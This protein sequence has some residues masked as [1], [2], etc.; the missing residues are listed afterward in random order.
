MVARF[1]PSPSEG[2][3]PGSCTKTTASATPLPSG[4]TTRPTTSAAA[5]VANA[6][7]APRNDVARNRITSVPET[8]A[9][10]PAALRGLGYR[11]C[12]PPAVHPHVLEREPVS[13]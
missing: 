11:Q 6:A 7:S 8:I 4:P 13:K 5:V 3:A 9:E 2:V 10:L 1:V 12:V